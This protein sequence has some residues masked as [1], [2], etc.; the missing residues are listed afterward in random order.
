MSTTRAFLAIA[1]QLGFE[2]NLE[3][4]VVEPRLQ[5]TPR[6]L[7]KDSGG[8]QSDAR[9]EQPVP[10]ADRKDGRSRHDRP[11]QD[12]RVQQCAGIVESGT[13]LHEHPQRER[14]LAALLQCTT[15]L[16]GENRSP[17]GSVVTILRQTAID[18]LRDPAWH[19]GSNQRERR[20]GLRHLFRQHLRRFLALER[21]RP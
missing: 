15:E 1:I 4:A 7:N 6:A 17:L 10:E 16:I 13:A 20:C 19:T 18:R 11:E 21:Q 8:H 12:E 3:V 5:Q 9:G 2:C 14:E